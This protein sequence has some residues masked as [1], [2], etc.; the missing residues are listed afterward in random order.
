MPPAVT[1]SANAAF[2]QYSGLAAAAT[3]SSV[4]P[5]GCIV[6][7]IVAGGPIPTLV[8]LDA[9]AITLTGP[10]GAVTLGSQFG[11]KG[12]Y[13][14]SLQADAIPPSGG[15][16]TFRGAGG[17]DVG[18]FTSALN[19][20]SPLLNWTNQ[21]G[22]SGRQQDAGAAGHLDREATREPTSS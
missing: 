7:Q 6:S 17:A 13:T 8:G 16:F 11:I 19:L 2:Q 3:G 22:R 10:S 20:S 12:A 9:G 18:P 5:G 4:S 21:N 1:N 14:A 15:T